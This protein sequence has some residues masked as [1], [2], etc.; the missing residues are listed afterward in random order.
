MKH[1]LRT[2]AVG[3]ALLALVPFDAL[4]QGVTS[5][6]LTGIVKDAQGGV[7]PGTTVVA[8]HQP[9][10]TTYTAVSQADGRYTIPGMRVG[11][12]YTVTAE[13]PG[14]VTEERTNISLNLGVMQDVS[15]SLR[16]AAVA[17]TVQVVAESSPIFS[18]GRTG[19][20]TAVTREDIATLPTVSARISDITRLTPQASGSSFA[21][22]DNRLNNIT[23]DGSYFNNSFGLGGEPG[24][25]TNVAPISLESLEQVQVSVA[26]YDVRQGSFIGAA[27]NTV[28]R[29]GTNSLSASV[30]HRMRND[31]W[32]GTEAAGNT[33]NPGTFTF[34]NTGGWAGGPIVR[35]RLFAFGTYENEEDKRPLTTFLANAGGQPVGGSITRV[36]ASDLDQLASFLQNRFSFDPGTYVGLQDPTPAKRYLLRSD[37]NL[38][39]RN[40]ISFRYNQLDS[41]SANYPSGSSSAGIGRPTFTTN[42]LAFS[43]STYQILENIKSG[44]GEWNTLL[45]GSM[46]NNLIVGLTSNDESRG[47][48]GK[49]FPFVDILQ[50]GVAMTSFGSEPFSVQNELRYK[51]FQFQDSLTKFSDRHTITVGVSAQR[52]HSDNVFWSCCPQSSYAYN[53]LA[54]FYTDANDFLANPNRTVSPVSLR[55]FKVRYS[56]VPDLD[57]PLQPLTVWYNGA[58]A[59][60]E[61]R[62]RTDLTVTAGVRADVSVFD[63]T[64]YPNAKADAL[65]FRSQSGSPIQFESGKLPGTKILWSPR[66]AMNWDVGGQQRTQVRLGTGLF[67]GPPL[68]VWISNQLGNSGVLIGEIT[69]QNTTAFPFNPDPNRYKPTNVTGQGA[70]SFELDVTDPD[71]KFPQVWR[72]N[73]AVDHKLPGGVIGTVEYIYNRDVNGTAYYNAN[74]PAAQTAFTGVDNRPRW[75]ANRINNTTPNVITN[76]I[77]LTNQ[78][79]GR[80][81]N[82]STSLSK[83]MSGL[84]LRGAYSYG[85]SRNAIDAGSTAFS[86][87]ANNQHSADPNNPGLGRSAYTQGHR[88]FVSASYSREYFSFGSTSLSVFWE[89]R[90]SNQNFSNVASYVFNGDMNGDGAS[91]NDLIYIPRDTSEMNFVQFAS[92][93]RTFTPAE[94]AAAFESYIQQDPYLK[95]HRGEYAKRGGLGMAMFNRMDLSLVQDVFRNIGGKRNAAQF[96][97]DISNFSNLLNRDWGVSKRLV[98]PTTGANGAQILTNATADAQGRASYRLAVVNGQLVSRTFQGNTGLADVYQIMLSFRYSFN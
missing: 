4:A 81:W 87:F 62:P 61:W 29:S 51:T 1:M 55:F 23:V 45:G 11:G 82:L 95:D 98:L 48:I 63:N 37:F 2:L 24:A 34:R 35:N 52:Y 42:Y 32:V 17:E 9:S 18:S 44:I 97:L 6:G 69:A 19:A 8:V 79:F 47:D 26:P 84:T 66:A 27:V 91:G 96:R 58:Y 39:D 14:F 92:G 78:G 93:G 86:S 20:A 10:G 3:V 67:T 54:D 59:Q 68:Y 15:F 33:V 85:Q 30:Y 65:T 38:T 36:L 46:A 71:F 41:S 64:A 74:L 80:S 43:G 70:S 7:V 73:A 28:T 94:Q 57:K 72:T 88:V 75:T 53:S 12:P 56:N 50:D 13:L 22:Q 16:I 31:G 77:I 21:G 89:A 83:S 76:A 40:K 90:P 60:D 5:A 49:L 25:R